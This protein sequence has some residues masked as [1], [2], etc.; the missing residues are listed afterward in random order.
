MAAVAHHSLVSH[1]FVCS[2]TFFLSRSRGHGSRGGNRGR[3]SGQG[4]CGIALHQ[5][6]ALITCFTHFVDR[7]M[8]PLLC[9]YKKGLSNEI[10]L[11]LAL[12]TDKAH[13]MFSHIFLQLVSSLLV[14]LTEDLLLVLLFLD[15]NYLKQETI[16]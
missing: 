15:K 12:W 5:S 16:Q 3:R 8:K 11:L 9:V 1:F 10:I 6:E 13:S 14:T 4:R 2:V 7:L